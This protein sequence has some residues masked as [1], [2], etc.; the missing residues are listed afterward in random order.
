MPFPFLPL[1]WLLAVAVLVAAL[2]LFGLALRAMDRAT[3]RLAD[4][5]RT[6]VL[7]GLVSGLSHWQPAA[8]RQPALA[9]TGRAPG[10]TEIVELDGPTGR[11]A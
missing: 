4:D 7:P 5:L 2:T 9:P 8:D 1:G 6:T 3:T 10:G 11:A